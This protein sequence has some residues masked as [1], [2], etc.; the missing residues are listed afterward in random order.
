M[1]V[2]KWV[3]ELD[4]MIYTCD[5]RVSTLYESRFDGV[6]ILLRLLVFPGFKFG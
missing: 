6:Y 3:S 2:K 5:L 1:V 4:F